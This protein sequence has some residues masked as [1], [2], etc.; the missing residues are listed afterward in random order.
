MNKCSVSNNPHFICKHLIISKMYCFK[1]K[2]S[3]WGCFKGV[4]SLSDLCSA[5]NVDDLLDDVTGLVGFCLVTESDKSSDNVSN[6]SSQDNE[7]E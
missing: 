2:A 5:G 1:V 6:E 3:W 4:S 7:D